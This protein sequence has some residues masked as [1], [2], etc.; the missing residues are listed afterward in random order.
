MENEMVKK[1]RRYK[2]LPV[3]VDIIMNILYPIGDGNIISRIKLPEDVHPI[4][5]RYSMGRQT[6]LFLLESEAFPHVEPGEEI[7]YIEGEWWS[8]S[9]NKVVLEANYSTEKTDNVCINAGK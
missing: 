9:R 7:P 4:T 1:D 2:I 5:V 3:G 6:F 8:V